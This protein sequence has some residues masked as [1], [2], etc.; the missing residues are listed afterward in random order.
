MYES[1]SEQLTELEPDRAVRPRI[2]TERGLEYQ[3]EIR[4]H[5]L[6]SAIAKR[7]RKAG[8]VCDISADCE[9]IDIITNQQK[10]LLSQLDRAE[11]ADESIFQVSIV[12]KQTET[13]Q[14]RTEQLRMEI[15]KQKGKTE[16]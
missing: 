5:N 6:R 7:K 15:N 4:L 11:S 2:P 1:I 10:D 16:G 14:N 3:R 13:I 12:E 9:D 8:N